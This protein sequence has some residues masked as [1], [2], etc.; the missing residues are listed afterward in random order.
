MKIRSVTARA[1]LAPMNR[2]VVTGG[3][4][5]EKAAFVLVDLETDADII[6]RSYVFAVSPVLAHSLK[7]LIEGIGEG[8]TG[9][10]VAPRP[11]HEKMWGG[12]KLAG[13]EGFIGWAVAGIDMAVWDAT[14]KRAGLPLYKLLGGE[15]RE[16]N[17]Y[18]SNGLGLI[19]PK[20]AAAEAKELA[21]GFGAVKVRLGYSDV[22][23]DVEAVEAVMGAV[24][25]GMPVMCDYN[26]CLSRA[27]AKVRLSEIDD[28]GLTWIEEPINHDDVDG[29]AT[30]CAGGATPIQLG[31]N[32]RSPAEIQRL[33]AAEAADFLMPDVAKIGGVT[34]W[35]NAAEQCAASRIR[36]STH[37]FPEVSLHM[38]AASPTAHWLEYVDWAEPF[39]AHKVEV[40]AGKAI[41]FDRPGTGIEWNE[42]AVSRLAI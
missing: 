3:G 4:S 25:D 31:E 36:L 22:E 15:R 35:M 29:Y 28:L 21:K 17:A 26:Q 42:A 13:T 6:G 38:M 10:D 11:L 30:L 33:I 24:P 19:G 27:D 5:V 23:T 41:P 1:V 7:A 37:L 32:A 40:K 9:L 2:P 14:A 34:P 16:I 12:L 18:N 8:L 39:L 20:A